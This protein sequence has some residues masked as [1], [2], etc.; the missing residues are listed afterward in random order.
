MRE[1]WKEKDT[2]KNKRK[3][4]DVSDSSER[5]NLAIQLNLELRQSYCQG[6]SYPFHSTF[7]EIKWHTNNFFSASMLSSHVCILQAEKLF[8][9]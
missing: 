3:L 1:R 8:L 9:A 2:E 5:N 4:L 7:L 6:I